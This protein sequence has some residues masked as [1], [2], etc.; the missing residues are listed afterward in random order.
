MTAIVDARRPDWDVMEAIGHELMHAVE[1]LRDSGLKDTA[2]VYEFYAQG[3]QGV[4]R[5]FET[6]EAIDAG[7]A[8]RR[9]VTSFAKVSLN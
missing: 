8:V 3:R 5:P 9:D 1:V 7:Y 2:S 6:Q 4:A